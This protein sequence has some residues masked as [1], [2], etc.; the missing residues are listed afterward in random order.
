VNFPRATIGVRT[1]LQG[2]HVEPLADSARA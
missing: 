2:D 1:V